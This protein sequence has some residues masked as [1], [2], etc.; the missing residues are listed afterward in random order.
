MSFEKK[1]EEAFNLTTNMQ[2]IKN[3]NQSLGTLNAA[4]L[5]S[6]AGPKAKKLSK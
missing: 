3:P 6:L 2:Q 4:N 1:K 5:A